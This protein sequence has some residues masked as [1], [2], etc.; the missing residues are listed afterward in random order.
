MK[1]QA[2][3]VKH[4]KSH[5][6]A[7]PFVSLDRKCKG[8]IMQFSFKRRVYRTGS[9]SF[10]SEVFYVQ[11]FYQSAFQKGIY[12]EHGYR[13]T[14]QPVCPKIFS[15]DDLLFY[16][17]GFILCEQSLCRYLLLKCHYCRPGSGEKMV[18]SHNCL[19]KLCL[20]KGIFFFFGPIRRQLVDS[21]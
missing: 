13:S 1:H 9:F 4:I 10:E 6:H 2:I 8:N 17:L 16:G 3:H 18:V 14:K 20:L 21:H 19:P 11:M 15:P 12:I 5:M 7:D